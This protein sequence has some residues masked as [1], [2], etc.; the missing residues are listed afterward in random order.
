MEKTNVTTIRLNEE[1]KRACKLVRGILYDIAY[2][3]RE[4]K[5]CKWI[6]NVTLSDINAEKTPFEFI[7]LIR[8]ILDIISDHDITMVG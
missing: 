8:D 2:P 1:E 7:E 5:F 6:Q 3:D 4:E